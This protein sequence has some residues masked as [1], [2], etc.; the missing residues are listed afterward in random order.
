MPRVSRNVRRVH[1][2]GRSGVSLC[3]RYLSRRRRVDVNARIR[4]TSAVTCRYC[5]ARYDRDHAEG[6]RPAA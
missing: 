3:G 5:R 4:F 6:R 1:L 2:V